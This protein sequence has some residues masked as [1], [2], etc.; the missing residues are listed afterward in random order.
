[1]LTTEGRGRLNA[2]IS[3]KKTAKTE[4]LQYHISKY[5]GSL[6]FLF[7]FVRLLLMCNDYGNKPGEKG[8]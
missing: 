6:R 8:V 4:F 5:N 3:I 1:M 7:F 2:Y